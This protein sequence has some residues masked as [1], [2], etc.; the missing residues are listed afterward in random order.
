MLKNTA[1]AIAPI[2]MQLFNMSISSCTFPDC[3]K[4]SN[5]SLIPKGGDSHCPS[6]YRPISL[7]S[8]LSKTFERHICSLI[9]DRISISD[10][11]WGFLPGKSTTGAVL[12]ALYDWEGLLNKNL[13]VL[14]AF[15][16]IRKAFDSVPHKCLLERLLSLDAPEH[17]VGLISSYLYDCS[18]QVCVNGSTSSKCHVISGVPQGSVLGP[19]LFILYVDKLTSVKLSNGTVILYADDICLYRR[20]FS[21]KDRQAFQ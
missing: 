13:E 17:I 10:N 16:D 19:L 14:V 6:N 11:Q 20:V 12:S 15:L 4:M 21:E 18:Q 2:V 8:V 5:V 7:L 1:T 9:S 3:W